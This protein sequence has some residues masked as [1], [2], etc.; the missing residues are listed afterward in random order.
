VGLPGFSNPAL[1]LWDTITRHKILL[2]M[3]TRN[4]YWCLMIYLFSLAGYCVLQDGP[5]EVCWL[6]D[7]S[8][9]FKFTL[10]LL[11]S[12]LLDLWVVEFC[13]AL[14]YCWRVQYMK[15][16]E[17]FCTISFPMPVFFS[18]SA[19]SVHVS[20]ADY[21]NRCHFFS[22]PSSIAS[23]YWEER[24]FAVSSSSVGLFSYNV[25]MSLKYSINPS[26]SWSPFWSGIFIFIIDESLCYI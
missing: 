15:C 18:I 8:V 4:T 23:Q 26:F 3:L 2:T 7:V 24:Q 12:L 17:F 10:L 22:F 19:V 20:H 9:P 6:Q 25:S 1:V 14:L 11:A 16:A 21:K 5:S 13:C